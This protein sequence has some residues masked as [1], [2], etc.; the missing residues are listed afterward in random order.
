[1]LILDE[2]ISGFRVARGG[3]QELYGIQADLTTLGKIIGGGLPVGAFVASGR[4]G[5]AR[6]E[7]ACLSSG[8]AVGGT[9]WRWRR[10]SQHWK[11]FAEWHLQKLEQ[12]AALLCDE[13]KSCGTD[14]MPV[15]VVVCTFF[16][17]REVGWTMPVQ[18]PAIRRVRAVFHAML[19]RGVHLRRRNLKSDLCHGTHGTR[20]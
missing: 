18:R 13:W 20:P 8:H 10:G 16:T 12:H 7:R 9:R 2:V 3:A 17:D 15:S 5:H 1:L 11:S 4:D 19:E 14:I 6:A